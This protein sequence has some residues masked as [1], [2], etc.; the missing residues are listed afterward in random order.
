MLYAIYDIGDNKYQIVQSENN[1]IKK[2]VVEYKPCLFTADKNG[3]YEDFYGRKLKKVVFNNEYEYKAAI[4]DYKKKNIFFCGDIHPKYQCLANNIDK[5]N[6]NIEPVIAYNYDI[7]CFNLENDDFSTPE[8][9]LNPVQSITIQNMRTGK[10]MVFGYEDYEITDIHRYSDDEKT[11]LFTVKKEDIRYVKCDNE[12]QL[13]KKFIK[14]MTENVNVI[15]GYNILYFD[16]TYIVN[17]CKKLGIEKDFVARA[18]AG[19]DDC[20]YFGLMQNIDSFPSIKKFKNDTLENNQLNTVAKA[21]LGYGKI[22]HSESFRLFYLNDF[23]KFIDY[24]I[25]DVALVYMLEMRLGIVKLMFNM[26]N[27]F[28]CNPTDTMSL[29]TYVDTAVYK[30]CLDNKIIIPA[31]SKNVKE[32]YIGGWV[33]DPV[34][35]ISDY[36]FCIDLESSYPNNIGRYNISPET[37][38]KYSELPED[39]L[40]LVL[41]L[42]FKITKEVYAEYKDYYRTSDGDIKKSDKSGK[43]THDNCA[44]HFIRDDNK[45]VVKIEELAYPRFFIDYS[46]KPVDE[47]IFCADLDKKTKLLFMMDYDE[48]QEHLSDRVFNEDMFAMYEMLI[49]QKLVD[50]FTDDHL[51]FKP[52]TKYCKEMNICITPNL[53]FYNVAEMG[54]IT[55]FVSDNFKHRVIFKNLGKDIALLIEYKKSKDEKILSK[56]KDKS[57]IELYEE[58][59]IKQ[60]EDYENDAEV[61]DATY[62]RVINGTYGFLAAITGRYYNKNL[63]ESITAAGQ[64]AATGF[65]K[66]M[67]KKLYAKDIYQDTDSCWG[68]SIIN[69]N[70][71]DYKIEDLWGMSI[72]KTE[73]KDEKFFA[74]L[75]ELKT[76]CYDV[77][78]EKVVQ[79]DIKYIMKHK[80]KK[81]MFRI[82]LAT[83]E[84]VNITE[85]HGVIVKRYNKYLTVKPSEIIEIDEIIKI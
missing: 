19:R 84:H 52:F 66:Y 7:E 1:V 8:L 72:N 24:N 25:I 69:T 39:F 77:E 6:F 60:L 3:K 18:K 28:F 48:V 68:E 85:D 21:Y 15:C 23:K 58:T 59:D 65:R 12:R 31:K 47:N 64:L 29:T 83:G 35:G 61:N 46:G 50:Y 79:R 33:E 44:L 2:K 70:V 13:L 67:R 10:Y 45:K 53:Q 76:L 38:I 75:P 55:K 49:T 82:E 30:Q 81:R 80:V 17:R 56:I 34:R 27:R 78:N 26:S 5:I 16:N 43:V 57:I 42:K 40:E 9:A 71:G 32:P 36:G 62:K 14:I 20:T 4:K 41:E 74:E 37:L 54:I 11:I 63:G 22:E 51:R 73:Y